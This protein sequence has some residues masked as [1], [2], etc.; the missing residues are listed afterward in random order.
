MKKALVLHIPVLHN[1]YIKLFEKYEDNIQTLFIIDSEFAST[2]SEFNEIRSVDP[3][4]IAKMMKNLGFKF[5]TKLLS[6]KNI[7]LL[8]N[9]ELVITNESVSRKL[10]KKY[11]PSKKVVIENTFL[12]WDEENVQSPN[13][14]HYDSTSSLPFDIKMMNKA[15]EVGGVSTD[16]WRRV[17]CVIVKNKKILISAFNEHFPSNDTQYSEGDPR[18]FIKSGKL[19]FLASSAHAEQMA[20]SKAANKGISLKGSDIY[21]STYPCPTCAKLAATAGVKKCYFQ[22]GNSYLDVE[23]VFK[24]SGLKAILVMSNTYPIGK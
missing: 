12:R 2:F 23:A 20:I 14:P 10:L 1:G 9:I 24:S 13:P 21:V 15:R 3:K 17:G 8:S 7:K 4:L 22:G 11:F 19:G 6:S 16:W 5:E 18:D